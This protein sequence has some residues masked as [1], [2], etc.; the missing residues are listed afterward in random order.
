MDKRLR[1]AIAKEAADQI[2]DLLDRMGGDE[3]WTKLC[4]DD[5]S[6]SWEARR[7]FEAMM[8]LLIETALEP[9]E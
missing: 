4:G 2:A 1:E 7:D 6:D 5:H 8:R 3:L 9:Q